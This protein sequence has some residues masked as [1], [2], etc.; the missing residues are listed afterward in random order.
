MRKGMAIISMLSLVLM[1]VMGLVPGFGADEVVDPI[2]IKIDNVPQEVF[3]GDAFSIPLIITN[4]HDHDLTMIAILP[5]A[6]SINNDPAEDLMW[7]VP[8]GNSIHIF[9]VMVTLTGAESHEEV[10]SVE[11]YDGDTLLADQN[12]PVW[13]NHFDGFTKTVA[14]ISP[15]IALNTEIHWLLEITVTNTED[16][17]WVE[18]DGMWNI[19]V[20]DTLGAGIGIVDNNLGTPEFDPY[21]ITPGTTFAYTE[22]GAIEF[23]WTVGYLGPDETA[24]L[25]IEIF[26]LGF[27]G[28]GCYEINAGATLTLDRYF[29]C[30]VYKEVQ[31]L[32]APICVRAPDGW[33]IRT[34]GFWKHQFNVALGNKKGN[35]HVPTESLEAYLAEMSANTIVPELMNL[36]LEGALAIF[37]TKN[38]ADMYDKAVMQLLGTWMNYLSGNGMW[39][40]DGDGVSESSVLDAINWAEDG[41]VNG[42]PDNYEDIKDLLD[43]LNNSGDE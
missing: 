22:N 39:D 11:I 36:D 20:T 34:I 32:A 4:P 25:I 26:T 30:T 37:K 38:N 27:S 14:L 7:V 10:I 12:N 28:P 17:D 18:N 21:S 8:P 24:T 2:I 35:Q 31:A 40:S 3:L 19:V 6:F 13:I 43:E 29:P 33:G 5:P 1:S 15:Y 16:W 42:S 23:T 41:L 9:Y